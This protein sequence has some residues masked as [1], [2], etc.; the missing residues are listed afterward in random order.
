MVEKNNL[1]LIGESKGPEDLISTNDPNS[2]MAKNSQL[3]SVSLRMANLYNLR[4]Q[5]DVDQLN[6]YFKV[7]RRTDSWI[8]L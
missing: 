8:T 4:I 1:K 6:H 5:F 3:M 7:A 2:L